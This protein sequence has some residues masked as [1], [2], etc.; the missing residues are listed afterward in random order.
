MTRSP[1]PA[2]YIRVARY[3]AAGDGQAAAALVAQRTAVC[4][5]ARAHGWAEPT[6]Y[7]DIDSAEGPGDSTRDDR[8]ALARLA[9]A[10]STGQ[11]DVLLI[12]VG[13]ICGLA[14]EMATLLGSCARHGVA[15][16][17]ITLQAGSGRSTGD[18]RSHPSV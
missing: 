1:R 12:G 9:S 15:V 16:E 6:V 4:R 14:R 13:T 18:S 10:I 2:A 17:C 3:G 5:A 11:H 8:P 7:L